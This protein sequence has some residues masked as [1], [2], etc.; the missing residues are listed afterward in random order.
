MVSSRSVFGEFDMSVFSSKDVHSI[1]VKEKKD[2]GYF[3]DDISGNYLRFKSKK[4]TTLTLVGKGKQS[5][6]TCT[7]NG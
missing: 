5:Q 7:V 1:E 6:V 3:K 2:W 4:A